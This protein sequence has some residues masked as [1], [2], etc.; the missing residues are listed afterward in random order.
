MRIPDD[1]MLLSGYDYA[2]VIVTWAFWFF[3][4]VWVG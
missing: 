2:F 1:D 3:L 4:G